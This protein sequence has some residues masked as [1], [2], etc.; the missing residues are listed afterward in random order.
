MRKGFVLRD[1]FRGCVQ[2]EAALERLGGGRVVLA[3]ELR[4]AAL[5][6]FGFAV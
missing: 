5:F 6:S 1:G 3:L 2:A 4:G